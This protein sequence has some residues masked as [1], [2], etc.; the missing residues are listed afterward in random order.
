MVRVSFY[1]NGKLRVKEFENYLMASI[2]IRNIRR[3]IN[4]SS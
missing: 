4:V 1:L 3:K 2:F